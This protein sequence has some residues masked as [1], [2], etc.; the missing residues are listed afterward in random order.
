MILRMTGALGCR[1]GLVEY[2]ILEAGEV[3]TTVVSCPIGTLLQWLTQGL[4]FLGPKMVAQ[5]VESATASLLLHPTPAAPH[6]T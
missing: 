2:K 5:P 4:V 3:E 1:Q 6:L